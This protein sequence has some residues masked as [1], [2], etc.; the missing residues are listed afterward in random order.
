MAKNQK[1]FIP[2]KGKPFAVEYNGTQ[3]SAAAPLKIW[4]AGSEGGKFYGAKLFLTDV[5]GGGGTRSINVYWSADGVTFVLVTTFSVTGGGTYTKVA[6]TDFWATAFVNDADGNKYINFEA[7]GGF[8][9]D[10]VDNTNTA[11]IE[12]YGED[13]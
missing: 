13:Y 6:F 12:S 11:A 9:I 1:N 2:Q 5:V 10:I 7:G 3:T 8:F 4:Q